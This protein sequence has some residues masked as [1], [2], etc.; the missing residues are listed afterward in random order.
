MP[1][2]TLSTDELR[3]A[4]MACRIAAHQAEHDAARQDNPRLKA[5]FVEGAQRYL[6]LAAKFESAR[7]KKC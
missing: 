3:D 5:S 7:V 4:A 1:D 2:V 6:T